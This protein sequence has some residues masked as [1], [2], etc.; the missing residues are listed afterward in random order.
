PRSEPSP[1]SARKAAPLRRLGLSALFG[2]RLGSRRGRRRGGWRVDHF[3]L[4]FP[5][6]KQPARIISEQSFLAKAFAFSLDFPLLTLL[7]PS[8]PLSGAVG[9]C[10][11]QLP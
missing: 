4:H 2:G 7:R 10:G 5:R 6:G 1:A 9:H 8:E 3:P 11:L